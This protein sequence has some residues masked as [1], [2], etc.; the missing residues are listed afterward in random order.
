MRGLDFSAEAALLIADAHVIDCMKE[1]DII[2]YGL[3]TLECRSP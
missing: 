3:L 2:A 1:L